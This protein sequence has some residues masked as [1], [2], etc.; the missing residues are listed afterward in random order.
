[1]E[2]AVREGDLIYGVI[3]GSGINQDGASN[4]ITA[5]N[6]AAQEQLIARVYE[7]FRIDP[8]EISYVEA[9]G[10]GTRLGDPVE[11]NA[12]V[13]AF[14][15]FT[16]KIGY[17]A[18]GSAKSHIGHTAAAAG[19]T[20]LIKILLSMQ[21][22][23]I[24]RL[25][26]FKALNPLIELAG[27]P[28]YIAAEESDWSARPGS[29][30]MAALNSFGHSGTNAHLVIKEYVG[31]TRHFDSVDIEQ[32]GDPIIVPLS[33]KTTEQ[34]RQKAV[35]LLQFIRLE[36][37][38]S[39]GG[40]KAVDLM[41]LGYTLQTCREAMEERVGFLVGSV[42]ELDKKLESY[43]QGEQLTEGGQRSG[44]FPLLIGEPGSQ[45]PINQWIRDKDMAKLLAVWV[46]GGALDWDKFYGDTKPR[47]M[48]LPVYPFAKE[49]YWADETLLAN[50]LANIAPLNGGLESIE[51]VIDRIDQGLMDENEGARRLKG[52][53][54]LN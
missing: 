51:D 25:L 29:P 33:A 37:T 10:T 11:A 48:R 16:A 50:R 4:G 12:L 42:Q 53:V 20:G 43:L 45:S 52:L 26:H 2:D 31:S 28:F 40:P 3:S 49:H 7:K 46:N 35:D 5:P 44:E 21:H 17:C 36:E 30:R 15:K 41:R 6:G 24:P 39:M 34:L 9:H 22:N 32:T 18:L 38:R 8:E 47:R 14:R 13:R 23:R 54:L 19:V 27:S 1:L